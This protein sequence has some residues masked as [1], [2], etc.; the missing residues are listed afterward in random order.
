MKSNAY[1]YLQQQ[2]V[3]MGLILL[4][5]KEEMTNEVCDKI[6]DYVEKQMWLSIT[7]P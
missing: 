4:Q 2:I 6:D 7:D 5:W 1:T 3:I